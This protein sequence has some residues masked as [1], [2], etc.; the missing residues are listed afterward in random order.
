MS[1]LD[2]LRKRVSYYGDGEA[3]DQWTRMRQDKL[4]SL[5]K[6][7]YYSYQAAVVQK[8]VATEGDNQTSPFFRC[9]INKEKQHVEYEDKEI[10][11][12]FQECSVSVNPIVKDND[13]LLETGFHTGTTFIWRHGNR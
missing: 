13:D 3:I 2:R 5:N 6:A 9:L 10:S 8:Y 12:P 4:R 7:L 11:I 1:G